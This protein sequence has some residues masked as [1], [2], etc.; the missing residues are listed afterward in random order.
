MS[1][2]TGYNLVALATGICVG[3]TLAE[4]DSSGRGARTE[5]CRGQSAGVLL[6]K[7][8]LV[9]IAPFEAGN[10]IDRGSHGIGSDTGCALSGGSRRVHEH[11]R[12]RYW[13]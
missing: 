11:S 13:Y 3:K 2:V 8:G 9:E 6:A 5:V 12:Q 7:L 1:K 10:E 4:L